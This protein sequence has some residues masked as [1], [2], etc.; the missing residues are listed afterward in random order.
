MKQSLYF[1]TVTIIFFS[2][3]TEEPLNGPIVTT[4]KATEIETYNATLN[5][6]VINEGF[7]ATSERGFVYSEKN[8][9]PSVSDSKIQNGYGKGTYS[10][11]LD[12]LKSNSK[13]YFKSYATNTKATAY[14]EVQSFTTLA[15]GTRD[16]KTKVV[17]VVSK[18]GKIW[19]DRNLGASRVATSINDIESYGD[20]YQWGRLADGHEKMNSGIITKLSST[21]IVGNGSFITFP[22]IGGFNDVFFSF[23][24]QVN[25]LD[26]RLNHNDNLWQGG[27]NSLNN[28]CPV[29]FRLPTEDEWIE[30]SLT[31]TWTTSDHV[32][33]MNSP[34][35]LPTSNFRSYSGDFYRNGLN[36]GYYWSSSRKA[37][38]TKSYYLTF[39]RA[40]IT[41][42]ETIRAYGFSVR[43]IKE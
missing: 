23:S 42:D 2:C 40:G 19:M 20:Y 8:A 18:T 12:N 32:G 3:K 25:S 17:E 21:D 30:E 41:Y 10:N 13:Y 9:N 24:S 4:I 1:I 33:S 7:T 22:S 35:K 5:G 15:T 27:V 11:K 29:G 6:E 26:W 43:C 34:L 31:W 37:G 38:S 16:T 14:G 39:D 36:N 28:V